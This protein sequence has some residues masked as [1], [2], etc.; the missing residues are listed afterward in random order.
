MGQ[1]G[2]LSPPPSDTPV[3]ELPSGGEIA[4]HPAPYSSQTLF[5]LLAPPSTPGSPP[6]SQITQ[7]PLKPHRP[8]SHC[9]LKFAK[10]HLLGPVLSCKGHVR[11]EGMVHF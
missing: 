10:A 4:P 2:P 7:G 8:P 11:G 6:N 1:A 9:S 3:L 5:S